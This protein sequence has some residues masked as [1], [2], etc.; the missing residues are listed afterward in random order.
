M[1]NVELRNHL[2]LRVDRFGNMREIAIM[3]KPHAATSRYLNV[4]LGE[5]GAAR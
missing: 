1:R 4:A 3:Q 5:S 2:K